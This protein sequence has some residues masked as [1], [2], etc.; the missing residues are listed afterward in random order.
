VKL[1]FVL[2]REARR[3]SD[4]RGLWAARLAARERA[5]ADTRSRS[6]LGRYEPVS[7][8]ARGYIPATRK[9]ARYMYIGIGTVLLILLIILLIVFVF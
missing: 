7:D 6:S 1:L 3:S 2:G 8:G 9:E 5:G 4:A